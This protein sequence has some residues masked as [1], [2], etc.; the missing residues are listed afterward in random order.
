MRYTVE[1][2][3]PAFRATASTL[4]RSAGALRSRS[5]T[6]SMIRRRVSAADSALA[7]CSYPR[8][9][10]CAPYHFDLTSCLVNVS[11]ENHTTPCPMKGKNGMAALDVDAL[12][13]GAG[14]AGLT[15]AATLARYGVM[16]QVVER[17]QR[18]S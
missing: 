18:L 2:A 13:V 5:I 6:A 10:L 14:P 4:I 17:K 9:T 12:V 1:R 15:A 7:F 3:T 8:A 11:L 16:V